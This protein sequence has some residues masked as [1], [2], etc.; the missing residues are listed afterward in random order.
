MKAPDDRVPELSSFDLFVAALSVLSLFNIALVIAPMS[1]Q[2]NTVILVVDSVLCLI[3]FSDFL[4]RLRRAPSKRGYLIRDKGWLDL[5]GSLP[6]PGLRVARLFRLLRAGHVVRVYGWRGLMAKLDSDRAGSALYVAVFFTIVVLEFGS[7]WVLRAESRSENAN[8][9]TASDAL[10]WSYT[11][12]TT[13]GYGDR[14]PVTNRG[15]L[16]GVAMMT[17][18]VGLFS[19]ITGYL[20]NFFL[21]PRKADAKAPNGHHRLAVPRPRARRRHLRSHRDMPAREDKP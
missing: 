11:T 10:W 8:I 16:A 12:I 19:V 4:L 13:V 5:V 2:A 9:Q 21:K 7:I 18:G 20:A 15:R 3:F 17:V 6:L 1:P 14:Y